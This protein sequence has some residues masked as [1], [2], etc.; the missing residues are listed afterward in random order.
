MLILVNRH[1]VHGDSKRPHLP[2]R[3]HRRRRLS[4]VPAPGRPNPPRVLRRGLTPSRTNRAA[5]YRHSSRPL[6]GAIGRRSRCAPSTRSA[7]GTRADQAS[8][9]PWPSDQPVRTFSRKTADQS[10]WPSS[11]ARQASSTHAPAWMDERSPF[12]HLAAVPHAP[13][14]WGASA[15]NDHGRRGVR[16]HRCRRLPASRSRRLTRRYSLD[17][18]SSPQRV[19]GGGTNPYTRNGRAGKAGRHFA[20]RCLKGASNSVLPILAT[21]KAGR[22]SLPK[23]DGGRCPRAARCSCSSFCSCS[24]SHPSSFRLRGG[25]LS[26]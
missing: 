24:S 2:H 7:T 17:R 23:R 11:G 4:H 8:A 12:A 14:D 18:C 15:G 10:L 19:A 3:R 25:P 9:S 16:D 5:A 13:P 6:P 1:P 20:D 22:S 21:A 26:A